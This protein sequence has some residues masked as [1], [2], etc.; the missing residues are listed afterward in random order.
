MAI[1]QLGMSGWRAIAQPAGKPHCSG[2][3]GVFC[4]YPT[5]LLWARESGPGVRFGQGCWQIVLSWSW[6]S[7]FWWL[8]LHGGSQHEC[9]PHIWLLYHKLLRRE[10]Q[11]PSPWKNS[12]DYSRF[13]L[14]TSSSYQ[15][16]LLFITFLL[17]FLSF[18]AL[19]WIRSSSMSHLASAGTSS[20]SREA[21]CTW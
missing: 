1:D 12:H 14:P 3:G 11:L 13:S 16:P 6:K 10:L 2:D 15:F 17:V 18:S 4:I 8:I 21:G 20:F 19:S 7:L 5:A 9:C